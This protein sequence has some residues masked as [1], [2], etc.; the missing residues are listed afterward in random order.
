MD[1]VRNLR[2]E[3][4]KFKIFM[5]IAATVALISIPLEADARCRGRLFRRGCGCGPRCHSRCCTDNKCDK[6][7]KPATSDPAPLKPVPYHLEHPPGI[8]TAN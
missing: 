3:S 2:G 8:Q 1:P 5:L 6:D 7:K 4:M